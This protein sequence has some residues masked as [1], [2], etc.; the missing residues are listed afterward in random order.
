MHRLINALYLSALAQMAV[1]DIALL[2]AFT[3]AGVTPLVSL[4][5]PW[6]GICL[7]FCARFDPP[8]AYLSQVAMS[9][10]I[11]NITLFAVAVY[12]LYVGPAHFF[13]FFA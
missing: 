4:E 12:V 13:V 11:I 5:F 7:A 9:L 3:C 1:I 6:A 10:I 8:P 2:V